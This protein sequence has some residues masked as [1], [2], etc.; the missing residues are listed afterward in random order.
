MWKP[1]P[2][3]EVATIKLLKWFWGMRSIG[4]LK[5]GNIQRSGYLA[6]MMNDRNAP[7]RTVVQ[8]QEVDR[9]LSK[10]ADEFETMLRSRQYSRPPECS[11]DAI[12]L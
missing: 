12:K 6:A 7:T 2:P 4:N 5:I 10:C 8:M 9:P 11:D 1:Q 3:G